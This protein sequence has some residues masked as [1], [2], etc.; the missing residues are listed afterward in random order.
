EKARTLYP[1]FGSSLT[2]PMKP[3]RH[4]PP[5]FESNGWSTSIGS[6]PLPY[7]VNTRSILGFS[8]DTAACSPY[9]AHL[10]ASANCARFFSTIP[11]SRSPASSRQSCP[12]ACALPSLAKSERNP[13]SVSPR[14]T[15]SVNSPSRSD[16]GA[17]TTAAACPWTSSRQSAEEMIVAHP[18]AQASSVEH[19]NVSVKA[20]GSQG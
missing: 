9:N 20:S 1:C 14:T 5:E 15:R 18:A 12:S 11:F 7:F 4:P 13:C 19:E 8:S 6:S 3:A 2:S 10:P 17:L 16:T